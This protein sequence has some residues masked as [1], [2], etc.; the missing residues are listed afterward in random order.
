MGMQLTKTDFIQY[1]NCP[2]SLWLLKN[3]PES[4]PAGEFSTFLQKITREGYEV[5]RYVRA[6]FDA[7]PDRR[8][9]FQEVFE[10]ESGLFAR[11]DALEHLDDERCVLY[12]IKSSTSV[13]TDPAH[14][15]IKDAAFQKICAE[16]SGRHIDAVYIVHLNGEYVR[17]GEIEPSGLLTFADVSAD[18]RAIE[19]DLSSQIDRALEFLSEGAIDRSQCSCLRSSR[20]HHCDTFEVFNPDIP[21]PS[22]Y[23]L[24]R[25]SQTKR[26]ELVTNGIFDLLDIPKDYPLSSNQLAVLQAA[27]AGAPIIDRRAVREF[28]DGWQFPLY[29]FDYETFASAVPI[30]DRASPHKHF[31]VQYSLHVLH[32]NGH[33]EHREFLER[34]AR[35]PIRLLEV[36]KGDI[37]PTG[38]IVSWHASFEKTRNREMA[39]LFPEFSD[40]L[41][42]MNERTVD[43]E[44]VFKSAYVDARFDGSTSIKKVL[45]IL[46]PELSYK[47]LEVQD[48]ASAMDAWEQ[49]INAKGPEADQRASS[50]LSYCKLDTFAMVEI[51]LFL[52]AL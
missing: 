7:S 21:K 13:K 41:Q 40:F 5:E 42:D 11:A 45:P 30:V 33:L 36:L 14:N 16:R 25:L 44:D 17:C 49:M 10:T 12:E 18:V 2:K 46:C 37:G 6:Y 32:E 26:N 29:F 22:I 35:L 50:L 4:Y 47:G 9:S 27:R 31:P 38:S 43:L 1:L 51:Y 39:L 52:R 48:G 24:P 28:L 3:E 19:A 8:I 15:H 20:A 34:E 23:S